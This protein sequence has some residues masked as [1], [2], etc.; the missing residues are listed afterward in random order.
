MDSNLPHICLAV[1]GEELDN[2]LI[3]VR[4]LMDTGAGATIGWLPYFEA[5]VYRN[6]SILVKIYTSKGGAY[7]P[8][9]HAWDC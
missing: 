1:G 7:S 2:E 3:M 8:Y 6:P 4:A 9:Y 5:L